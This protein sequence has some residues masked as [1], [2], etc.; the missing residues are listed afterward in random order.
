MFYEWSM[1]TSELINGYGNP[2]LF[3]FLTNIH[4]RIGVRET[5]NWGGDKEEE[6]WS[7]F[8]NYFRQRQG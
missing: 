8:Q 1:M 6:W 7:I 5:V 2:L 3:E 4:H